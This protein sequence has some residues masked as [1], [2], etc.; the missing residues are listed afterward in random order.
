[1][2]DF[3]LLAASLIAQEKL[4]GW[5]TAVPRSAPSEVSGTLETHEPPC[6][7]VVKHSIATVEV[8]QPEF[9]RSK[10]TVPSKLRNAGAARSSQPNLHPSNDAP[11]DDRPTQ[12]APSSPLTA[13][14]H[15]EVDPPRPQPAIERVPPT[16]PGVPAPLPSPPLLPNEPASETSVVLPPVYPR[17]HSGGPTTGSQLY[18]QRWAALQA[19]R[20]Y[21]R[22]PA[23]SYRDRWIDAADQPT[24][25]QWQQ[26]LAQEASV[27]ASAQG[28]NRLT[29]LL[30][31]SLSLWLPIEQLPSDRFWLNQGISGDTTT[32]VLRR[33]SAFADT[34]P[35]S[36]HV[37]IGINDLRQGISDEA[38]LN[39]MRQI[40]RQL[41]QSHPNTQV[42][43][44]SI[45][46]T[47]LVAIPAE[48]IRSLNHQIASM[49]QQERVDFFDLQTYFTDSQGNLRQDLTTDGLHLN[50]NG[51]AVWQWAMQLNS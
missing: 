26:L 51:Y 19:G 38:M 18:H 5:Q 28:S 44:Y 42:L 21:T 10:Q 2:G 8:H 12:E 34:T 47:R 48:R 29:V 40:M 9:S 25:Q 14:P 39:N 46:P 30:G 45:L 11:S 31:D 36:I 6:A 24:Y 49:A 27:M 43:M 20:L 37:M 13:V 17:Q 7:T 41:R 33:L 35:D 1:M 32:G 22:L 16:V 23:N 50:P 3:C 15:P 4:S